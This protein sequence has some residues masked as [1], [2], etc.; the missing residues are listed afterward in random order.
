MVVYQSLQVQELTQLINP[1]PYHNLLK[2]LGL[3]CYAHYTLL[4]Q[5]NQ[6]GLVAHFTAIADSIKLQLSYTMCHHVLIFQ[7]SLKL[8]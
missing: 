6:K 2:K 5:V 7:L 3:C 1:L 8:F 4:Q